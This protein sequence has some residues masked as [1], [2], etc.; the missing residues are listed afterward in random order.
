MLGWTRSAAKSTSK[1]DVEAALEQLLSACGIATQA[2]NYFPLAVNNF[3][4]SSFE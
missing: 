2:A 3:S 1:V 4:M